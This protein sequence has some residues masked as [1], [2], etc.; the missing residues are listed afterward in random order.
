MWSFVPQLAAAFSSNTGEVDNLVC[1]VRFADEEESVF[2]H[3]AAHYEQLFNGAASDDNS[4]YNYFHRA[5]YGQL[6]WTSTFF[7]A[8]SA[9]G[10]IV[11]YKAQNARA[12]YQES[13]VSNT[14]G[15]SGVVEAASR[16]Q[17][18]V[19]E[20][21][22]YVSANLPANA[23][24]DKNNDG[25][26]DNLCIVL[27]G[28]SALSSSKLLWPQRLDL[29]LPDEMAVYIAGKKLTG[30]LMVFDAANGYDAQLRGIALNTG[31][32]CHE[33]SHS[34]GTYD[35]YHVNDNLNPVG[36]WDLM[37]DNQVVAQQM[38]AYTKWRYCKWLDEIPEIKAPG[39]YTLNPI[40]GTTKENI[41]FK[42]CP[43][44]RDEYFVVEY[45]RKSGFDANLPGEGLL[46]YRINPAYRGGN[47]NYNGTTRLDEMYVL[48]PGGT[49]T[50]DGTIAEALFSR[51]SGRTQ[52]GG[53][54]S[55]KAFYSDGTESCLA[56]SVVSDCGET[57]SFRFEAIDS[58]APSDSSATDGPIEGDV[59]GVL[60]LHDGFE[61]TANPAGWEIKTTGDRTWTWLETTRYNPAHTGNYSMTMKEAWSDVHQDE[62]LISPVLS[63]ATSMVFYSRTTAAQATPKVLPYYL[64]EVSSDNGATWTSLFNANTDQE[65][66]TPLAYVRVA[67]DLSPYVSEQM[68]VR[69]HAYDM[70]G[71]GLSYYWQID[72][73]TISAAKADDGNGISD[74]TTD[75]LS[76]EVV[77]MW[78]LNGVRVDAGYKG[79]KIVRYADGRVKK[80]F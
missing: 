36:V 32:L 25:M 74:A 37:S 62:Y 9:A 22:A 59:D 61:D 34:L 30:Y 4:V 31:V 64:V 53:S 15:Y 75:A 71:T 65:K 49:T 21:A 52:L 14:V 51:E 55:Q 5:S 19:Q 2:E 46:V 60:L 24:I 26:V 8:A 29:A 63:G 57:L 80:I 43:V 16:R 73:V 1:F 39:T 79:V 56:L 58:V 33:M 48:R 66:T 76:D 68:R 42:L 50:A 17:A 40:D 13:S 67:L 20:V 69:F 11:S 44:G 12:Y 78:S 27:S 47:V 10:Q 7:P 23:N 6:S 72:N 41:A 45:R 3:D 28:Q 70:T 38:S 54:S 77:G 35:L 18:L